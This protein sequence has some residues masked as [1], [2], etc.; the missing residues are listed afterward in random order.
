MSL[1]GLVDFLHQIAAGCNRPLAIAKPE[2]VDEEYVVSFIDK[3]LECRLT[4][5]GRQALLGIRWERKVR[6]YGR[7]R[8]LIYLVFD[9][10]ENNKRKLM[11][12][13]LG[14]LYALTQRKRTLEPTPHK[15]PVP[16][17]DEPAPNPKP[18]TPLP[19]GKR[20]EKFFADVKTRGDYYVNFD[21]GFTL[22]YQDQINAFPKEKY[23][24]WKFDFDLQQKMNNLANKKVPFRI[25]KQALEG[26]FKAAE[27]DFHDS[28]YKQAKALKNA[29]NKQEIL[30]LQYI[31]RW[32]SYNKPT[33]GLEGNDF[34]FDFK[35]EGNRWYNFFGGG[36]SSLSQDESKYL[37]Y[38][39]NQMRTVLFFM[40]MPPEQTFGLTK[41]ARTLA[42]RSKIPGTSS[43]HG[44]GLVLRVQYYR[45]MH[46]MKFLASLPQP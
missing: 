14:V 4:A 7:P 26:I 43:L 3:L 39:I 27:K 22:Q 11:L 40:C 44:S 6:Q 41:T 35:K 5:K 10:I 46:D 2:V 8:A 30:A 31:L 29:N 15:P 37:R 32:A 18:E 33:L 13:I 20:L 9:A 36:T 34:Q 45:D 21:T 23:S 17:P 16:K 24:S 28:G 42:R 25:P 12:F 38:I 19:P 1:S